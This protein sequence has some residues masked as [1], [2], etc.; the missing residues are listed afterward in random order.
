MNNEGSS[1][2]E[3]ASL[4]FALPLMMAAAHSGG[5]V[6]GASNPNIPTQPRHTGTWSKLGGSRVVWVLPASPGLGWKNPCANEYLH[7]A[8][9]ITHVRGSK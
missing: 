2:N 3:I 9:H 6:S 5:T 8:V 1:G 4:H 7:V